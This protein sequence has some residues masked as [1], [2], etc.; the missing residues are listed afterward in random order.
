VTTTDD[1]APAIRV[2][3]A[4]D[5]EIVRAGLRVLLDN[6]PG[7]SVVGEAGDG[8]EALEV[9]RRVAPDVVL[10]DLSMPVHPGIDFISALS[11][12]GAV[13]VLVLTAAIDRARTIEVLQRGARGVVLKE[14]GP[15]HL[16]KAIR[17]V[18]GGE[19]W[20]GRE[21]VA[22]LVAFLRSA[23]P[24][25]PD[26]RE[27]FRLTPRELEIVRQVAAGGTNRDIASVLGISEDTVKQHLRNVFDK[28][29]VSNRLELGLFAVS[30]RLV[31]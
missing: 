25:A 13:R 24:P 29:G 11:A 31:E 22:D 16:F 20:V 28:L 12:I 19:M 7:F 6:A 1:G 21:S 23:M 4:D 27:R 26:P 18:V 30:N 14:C 9:A 2:L 5:H 15:A 17:A 10:L 3:I 8:A